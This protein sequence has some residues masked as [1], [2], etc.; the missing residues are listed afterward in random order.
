[1]LL[2]TFS[3]RAQ[4]T[5]PSPIRK[6]TPYAQKAKALGKKVY[7]LN[8]GQPDIKSPKE[9]LEGIKLF[10]QEIVEYENSLGNEKLR[11]AWINYFNKN[12]NLNFTTQNIQITTSC[13]ESLMFAFIATCDAGDEILVF[14][15]TYANYNGFAYMS[16]VKLIP[17]STKIEQ[18]FAL[19]SIQDIEAK[20]SPK[21][22][23]ILYCSPNNPTGTVF[24]QE[25]LK[26]LLAV[27]NK[28]NLFLI[29][30]ETYREFVYDGQ[31]PFSIFQLDPN[32]PKII[33]VDSL[34]KRFSLC[35]ARIGCIISKN[36]A[37]LDLILR[38]AQARLASPTIEQFAATHMLKHISDDFIIAVRK[39]Y[40]LRRNTLYQELNKIPN[41]T[42]LKPQGAFYT[43]VK[44]PIPDAEHF[45]TWLLD[46]FSFNNATVFVAPA[47][48]FYI[49]PNHRKNEIRIAYV[50]NSNEINK[51]I[52][53]LERGLE[54]Y[55]RK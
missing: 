22:K 47:N 44:L 42:A 18:N 8:I 2:N 50:L 20:I 29:A 11:E 52:E 27:C 3:N 17:V 53:I 23:A 14:D 6:L 9:F 4:N 39:E 46:E 26:K 36:Q 16:D 13:S 15:P 45:A 41:I 43:L 19:P 24:S 10:D 51:A 34:S 48:G 32:D 28:Y 1:M 55:L 30:D 35:G 54:K 7:H 25:E 40:E 33:V 12:L 5:P 38:F 21:T 31:Q 37:L 49:E